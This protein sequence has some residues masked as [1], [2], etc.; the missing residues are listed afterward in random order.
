M[1]QRREFTKQEVEYITTLWN[2]GEPAE[3]LCRLAGI[4]KNTL[5][6]HRNCGALVH[7]QKRVKGSGRKGNR[8]DDESK[9]QLFG[10]SREEWT[11]RRDAIRDGWSLDE[12]YERSK[13]IEEQ[14][15]RGHVKHHSAA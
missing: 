8:L 15:L 1:R 5:D 10:L 13:G 4:T 3:D 2:A 6:Y 14:A 9:Q 7:L 11:A 12:Q